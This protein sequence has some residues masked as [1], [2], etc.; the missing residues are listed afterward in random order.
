MQESGSRMQLQG[1]CECVCLC[2]GVRVRGRNRG[3]GIR[4]GGLQGYGTAAKESRR[5]ADEG[6]EGE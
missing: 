4:R 6:T 5:Q 3:A 1:Q 2:S